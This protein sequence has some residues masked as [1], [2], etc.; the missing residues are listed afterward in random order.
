M[1]LRGRKAKPCDWGMNHRSLI[2]FGRAEW[3][4][5]PEARCRA[6]DL[7]MAH[8]TPGMFDYPETALARIVILQVQAA[9]MTGKKIG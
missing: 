3:V 2:A 7:I 1:P 5:A 4:D 8:Y 6:L 9:S